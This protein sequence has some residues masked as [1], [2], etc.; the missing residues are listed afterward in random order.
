MDITTTTNGYYAAVDYFEITPVPLTISWSDYGSL[1]YNGT[2]QGRLAAVATI[3]S[4]GG[5]SDR[6]YL[7]ASSGYSI[8][9]LNGSYV[10]NANSFA[11]TKI[12][13]GSYSVTVSISG[14]SSHNGSSWQSVNA[15]NYTIKSGASTSWNIAQRTLTIN[16]A[17]TGSVYYNGSLQGLQLSI[18]NIVKGD[19]LSFPITANKSVRADM[20]GAGSV[21][22]STGT[23]FTL[24][25]SKLSQHR[26]R[27]IQSHTRGYVCNYRGQLREQQLHLYGRH[28]GQFF[29]CEKGHNFIVGLQQRNY[30]FVYI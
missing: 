7:S 22:P 29:H 9:Y 14:V 15:D 28:I 3:K 10:D 20:V 12:N 1:V 11:V 13:A 19:V 8:T 16:F 5:N 26:Y 24:T 6:I 21:T 23:S 4:V 25:N 18:T 27:H 17:N 30:G 2:S